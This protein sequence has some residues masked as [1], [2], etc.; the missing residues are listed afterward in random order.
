V[1]V[2]GVVVHHHMQV[3][4]RVATGHELEEVDELAMSVARPAGVGDR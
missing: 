3:S 2:G 1:L 4:A